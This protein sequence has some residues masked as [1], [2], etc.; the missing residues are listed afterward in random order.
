MPLPPPSPWRG[1]LDLKT[2]QPLKYNN[3]KIPLLSPQDS[4]VICMR[5]Q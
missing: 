3:L 2:L 1:N 5:L 4:D